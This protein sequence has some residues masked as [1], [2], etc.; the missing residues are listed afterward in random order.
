[1]ADSGDAT[2]NPGGT[3]YNESAA[4]ILTLAEVAASLVA[5]QGQATEA[6]LLAEQSLSTLVAVGAAADVL[7]LVEQA[8]GA[9]VLPGQGA[10]TLALVDAGDGTIGSQT[11]NESAADV[12]SLLD[13]GDAQVVPAIPPVFI[14][15]DGG[16]SQP[17]WARKSDRRKL[18]EI[19]WPE[20]DEQIT[21][22]VEE[23]E[24]P[25]DPPLVDTKPLAEVLLRAR[26]AIPVD[27]DEDELL[28]LG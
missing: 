26:V 4:E 24:E 16:G 6:I 8:A 20:E 12:L 25:A 15:G 11:F 9:L 28:L 2:V 13:A 7:S 1:L 17:A 3:T 27:D 22:A 5:G 21:E 18:D 23:L 14:V 10:D 19:L